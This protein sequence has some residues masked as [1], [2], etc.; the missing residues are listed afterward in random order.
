MLPSTVQKLG[1]PVGGKK[2]CHFENQN[3]EKISENSRI[4]KT[5]P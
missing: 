4:G 1:K 2:K 5:N 3:Q